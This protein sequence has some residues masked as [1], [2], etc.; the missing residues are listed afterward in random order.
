LT[1][2]GRLPEIEHIQDKVALFL[3]ESRD[4]LS[5]S[6]CLAEE[7]RVTPLDLSLAALANMLRRLGR[8]GARGAAVVSARPSAPAP[9]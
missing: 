5:G 7:E 4:L 1:I 6:V 3:R 9:R 2:H 8:G